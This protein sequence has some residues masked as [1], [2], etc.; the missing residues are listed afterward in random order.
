ME[1]SQTLLPVGYAVFLWWGA[2]GF[3]LYLDGLPKRTFA[4][5]FGFA[6]VLLAAA[7]VV[8]AKT[9]VSL[10]A[11]SA[12]TAFTASIVVWAWMEIGF[13]T[14]QVTGPRRTACEANCHGLR[15]MVHAIEAI[16]YH[17]VA[18]I[19]GAGLIAALTWRAPNHVALYT[20]LVLWVMRSSAK[21]N[22]F[23]G[24]RNLGEVFLPEHLRYLVSFLRRR[25]M[26]ALFP[27]SMVLGT[28]GTIAI[29]QHAALGISAFETTG[30]ALVAALLGLAVLEHGFMMLPV[31]VEQIW[32]WGFRSRLPRAARRNA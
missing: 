12:F 3:I 15:H 32:G 6:T 1:L 8:I 26:N 28:L 22:L 19:A 7:L 30:A 2:T 24:V 17:E 14:G 10:T 13:L 23:L 4:T 25:R 31:P 27:F 21:V 9:A 16:L 29:A 5:S 11:L 18:I 20:Y